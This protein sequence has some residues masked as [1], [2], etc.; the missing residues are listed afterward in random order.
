MANNNAMN[1]QPTLQAEWID[2]KQVK[3][4]FS[5][6]KTTLY[7]LATTGKIK[8]VSLREE[9]NQRGKRLFSCDS[10]RAFLEAQTLGRVT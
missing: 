10:I 9:G 2:A 4:V 6:G 8:T 3:L 1:T 7:H 5:I